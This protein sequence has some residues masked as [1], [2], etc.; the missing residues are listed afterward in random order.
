MPAFI[1]L[2]ATLIP[3]LIQAGMAIEPVIER[4]ISVDKDNI[5]PADWDFLHQAQASALAII[6]DTSKDVR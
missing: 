4:L 5:M 6:N 2:A 3:Q 1:A